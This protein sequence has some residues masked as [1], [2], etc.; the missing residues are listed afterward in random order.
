MQGEDAGGLLS[1]LSHQARTELRDRVRRSVNNVTELRDLLLELLA[2][3]S[4][5]AEMLRGP[6][7]SQRAMQ[8]GL[9]G[10]HDVTGI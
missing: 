5:L 10:K 6:P 9:R 1:G 2:T 4:E 7:V 3:D 8:A